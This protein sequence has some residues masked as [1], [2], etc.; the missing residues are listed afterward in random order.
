MRRD[1]Y[2][3]NHGNVVNQSFESKK[4]ILKFFFFIGTI[5][6]IILIGFIIYT[7]FQNNKCN[8]LYDYIKSATHEYLEDE[9]KLPSIEGEDVTTSIGKLYNENYLNIYSTENTKCSGSIKTTKYENTYVY[10]LNLT[11]CNMCTTTTKYKDWSKELNSLPNKPIVDVVP[12]YNYYDRQTVVTDWSKYYDQSD[13]QE[14][15]SE[16]GI[17]LPKDEDSI[18]SKL[19]SL[20]DEASVA[21]IQSQEAYFYRYKDKRWKWYDIKGNYSN[22]SSEKPTG[23][24]KKDEETVMYTAWSKYSLNYPGDKEYREIHK[25]TGYKFYYKEDGEK[26]YANNKNYVVADD[27][28]RNKYTQHDTEGV[29]MYS[30]RDAKWRWYNGERRRYSSASSLKPTGYNFKDEETE[31]ETSYSNW[32]LVSRVNASNKS[33][34]VEEKKTMVRFRYIYEILS[35]PILREPVTKNVFVDKVGMSVP[36]FVQRDDYKMEVSYKFRYRKR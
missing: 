25:S 16:Y 35:D 30:Y 32:E 17:N 29:D 28:D 26:I 15:K 12:Y 8:K 11:N 36:D 10:T 7:A 34:R 1:T 19:P 21:E 3:D 24:E 18:T 4:I 9:G 20:P 27:I 13:L 33:Y 22:Y 2:V 23:Y 14:E 31:I 5:L 6:P